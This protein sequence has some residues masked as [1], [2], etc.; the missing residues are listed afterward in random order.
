MA[1]YTVHKA[2]ELDKVKTARRKEII[3]GDEL[4]TRYIA[5]AKY[6]G[7][8][9]V[10]IVPEEG[11]VTIESRTGETVLSMDH[12]RAAYASFPDIVPGVYLGEAWC[13]D[14]TFPEISGWFRKRSTTEDTMRLQHVL[15]DYLTLIEWQAGE[16]ELTYEERVARLPEQFSAVPRQLAPIWL[17][18][19]FGVI[20]E[21]WGETT[22]QRVC[23]E[24]VAAGG[25]DG[26]IFRDPDGKWTRG[27]GTGGEII[28][29]KAKFTFDLRVTGYEEGKGKHAG[30]IGTLVVSY[31]GKQ[32]GAGTGLK[33]SE[34][35]IAD[36][37]DNWHGQI[38]EIECLGVTE[39]GMLREPRLKGIR[40]DKTE[41]DDE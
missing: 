35:S 39:D 41:A 40:H 37:Y 27:N 26:A 18:E 20:A 14:A 36:F 8:N 23:N 11:P 15:F 29:V 6:D 2:V 16:S 38:V 19:T 7:C 13:P 5:Q 25:Y 31:K 32:Q 21:N 28:K 34:R 9:C 30:R 10:V 12:V 4:R 33:D 22:P 1:E 17:A 24:L 3:D